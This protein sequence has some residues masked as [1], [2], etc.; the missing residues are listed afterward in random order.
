MCEDGCKIGLFYDYD[1]A[2]LVTLED[3]KE[4]EWYRVR[5]ENSKRELIPVSEFLDKYIEQFDY[6]PYCGE[7]IDWKAMRRKA[8]ES[9]ENECR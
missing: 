2:D 8:K 7:K 6:C 5:Y 4:T 1:E 3:I 9:E